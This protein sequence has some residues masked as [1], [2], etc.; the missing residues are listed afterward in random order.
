MLGRCPGSLLFVCC[1]LILLNCT[2]NCAV[3]LE[4]DSSMESFNVHKVGMP[5]DANLSV[6]RCMSV[7]MYTF[8]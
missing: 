6:E 7:L 1:C 4:Y 5:G 8:L 2:T 3:I